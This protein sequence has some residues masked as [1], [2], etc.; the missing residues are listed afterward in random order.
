MPWGAPSAKSQK[1]YPKGET[2]DNIFPQAKRPRTDDVDLTEPPAETVSKYVQLCQAY[3]ATNNSLF[4]MLTTAPEV[5]PAPP[6]EPEL[7]GLVA[8]LF[9]LPSMPIRPVKP[10]NLPDDLMGFYKAEIALTKEACVDVCNKS[11]K[12]SGSPTWHHHRRL[13]ITASK[14]HQIVRAT[15]PHTLRG[16]FFDN[17]DLGGVRAVQYG[18]RMESEAL[19]KYSEEKGATLYECGLVIH[20][21]QPFISGSPDA[22]AKVGNDTVI[23]EVKCPYSCAGKDIKVDFIKNG[24]LPKNHRYYGMSVPNVDVLIEITTYQLKQ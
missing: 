14:F 2:I 11:L 10:I 20:P 18:K 9:D 12:Q 3:G 5:R 16:Y 23:V 24:T 1:L 7:N 8:G 4:K 21:L 17:S 19:K 6:P 22:I 15:K 13:H